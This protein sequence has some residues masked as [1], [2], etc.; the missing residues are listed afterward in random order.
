MRKDWIAGALAACL[1]LT[2]C[3]AGAETANDTETSAG[4][5]A[6]TNTEE[7]VSKEIFSMDTYMTVTAYGEN[8]QKAVDAA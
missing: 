1:L 2:G 4:S 6:Q 8:G 3:G 5:S 7:P